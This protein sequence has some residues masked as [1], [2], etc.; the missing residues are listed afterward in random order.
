MQC[1]QYALY[2]L[3]SLLPGL[4]NFTP[5]THTCTL[6]DVSKA[7]NT[8]VQQA[9]ESSRMRKKLHANDNTYFITYSKYVVSTP[10]PLS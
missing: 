9:R 2:S 1:T 7:T 4:F 5:L 10:I 8:H 3:H 6:T